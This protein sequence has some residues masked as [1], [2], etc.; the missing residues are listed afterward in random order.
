MLSLVG[1]LLGVFVAM[2]VS[3]SLVAAVILATSTVPPSFDVHPDLRVMAFTI[4]LA[5]TRWPVVFCGAGLVGGSCVGGGGS[6][7][8]YP[9]GDA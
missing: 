1:A 5:T 6:A 9:D 7:V 3:E 2:W 8:H 4:S